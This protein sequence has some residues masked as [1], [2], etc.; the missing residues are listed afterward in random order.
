ML[1]DT[2]QAHLSTETRLLL[3]FEAHTLTQRSQHG[4]INKHSISLYL[5]KIKSSIR[6][7]LTSDALSGLSIVRMEP[8]FAL[9]SK[10]PLNA[11]PR[12]M[13]DDMHV[14]LSNY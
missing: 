10:M 8:F 3:Y 12:H 11:P 7:E 13:S 6:V 1:M 9:G 2:G 4:M 14:F 5:I